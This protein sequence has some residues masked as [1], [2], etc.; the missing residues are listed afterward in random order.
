MIDL[1]GLLRWLVGF[2]FIDAAIACT[3]NFNHIH[4][5]T[6]VNRTGDVGILISAELGAPGQFNA[7]A[8]ILAVLVLPTP[9]SRR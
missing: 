6:R 9:R 8:K 3:V 7:L 1:V 4:I 5:F 2:D